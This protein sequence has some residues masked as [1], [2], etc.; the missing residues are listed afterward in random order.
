MSALHALIS[1]HAQ[2][3]KLIEEVNDNP[4]YIPCSALGE[5]EI[6]SMVSIAFAAN[7]AESKE[8]VD[9]HG[10]RKVMLQYLLTMNSFTDARLTTLILK[11]FQTLKRTKEDINW[12]TLQQDYDILKKIDMFKYDLTKSKLY[13]SY[14]E[15]HSR[16]TI[17]SA[18][19]KQ[20][21]KLINTYRYLGFKS[22]ELKI[23][24]NHVQI[25]NI[26]YTNS[27]TRGFADHDAQANMIQFP[28]S[29]RQNPGLIHVE[30]MK[31]EQAIF[32][33]PIGKQVILL[34]FAN[35]RIPGGSF[36]YGGA[37][38]EESICYNSD[39]YRALL[40]FK[41]KKFNGGFMI[42]EYGG[43]YIKNVTFFHPQQQHLERKID[44]IAV[45]C[46][47]FTKKDGLYLL[48]AK[49]IENTRKK[50]LTLI[51]AAQ[52]NSDG[53]GS[54]TYLLLGPMGTG[55]Y[56]NDPKKIAVLLAEELQSPLNENLATQQRHTFEQ[57]WLVTT[58]EGKA[59]MFHQCF[60]EVIC[61]EATRSE[62][63]I[64]D[65]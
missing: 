8:R 32:K 26:P 33:V 29:L 64:L 35:D 47:D 20:T 18:K 65:F 38:Q 19:S 46:Y 40:D 14:W 60:K 36:L 24:F 44:V 48:P 63:E 7:D 16:S 58:N 6:M 27:S 53:N 37:G 3:P 42:P 25:D 34:H 12:N 13:D 61:S 45:S 15:L 10:G 41:Y 31:L 49:P 9:K 50:I 11:C 21:R 43:L 51:R 52:A 1:K 62:P 55:A 2:R 57:V 39:V 4:L 22:E 23:Y 17:I 28:V 56:K 5:T 54:N 59:D 30:K